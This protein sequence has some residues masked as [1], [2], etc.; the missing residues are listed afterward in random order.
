MNS[1]HISELMVGLCLDISRVCSN[2]GSPVKYERSKTRTFFTPR[3][4]GDLKQIRS[5]VQYRSSVSG[6]LFKP[7]EIRN[8]SVILRIDTDR[9]KGIREQELIC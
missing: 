6:I 1:D 7:V 8:G 3:K 2:H 5:I 9:M 4:Q